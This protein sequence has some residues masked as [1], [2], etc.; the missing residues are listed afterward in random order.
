VRTKQVRHE[1]GTRDACNTGAPAKAVE[2]LSRHRGTDESAGEIRSEGRRSEV[3]PYGARRCQAF[4]RV[5]ASMPYVER[6]SPMPEWP[7]PL[8]GR[9]GLTRSQQFQ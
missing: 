3:A 9:R 2:D 6:V 1:P 8:H 4:G 7:T 5:N